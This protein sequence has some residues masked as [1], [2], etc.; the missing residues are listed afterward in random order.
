[1]DRTVIIES[2]EI[3]VWYHADQRMIHH[4]MRGYCY[5]EPLRAAFQ[6]GLAAMTKYKAQ[7][8]LSDDRANGPLSLEDEAW[9]FHTWGPSAVAA[10][11]KYW[12]LVLPER[13]VERM[14]VPRFVELSRQGGITARVFTELEPA[15]DWL[16]D[17]SLGRS[18]P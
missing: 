17:P 6:A 3:I 10:G 9:V 5:D 8:W 7:K 13:V 12:A 11:W 1:M 2:D 18:E 4:Q 14:N 16:A 15:F